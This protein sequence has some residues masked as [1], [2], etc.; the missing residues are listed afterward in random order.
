MNSKHSHFKAETHFATCHKVQLLKFGKIALSLNFDSFV[1][2]GDNYIWIGYIGCWHPS[3]SI[4][5]WI[6][7]IRCVERGENTLKNLDTFSVI[8]LMHPFSN[9][10]DCMTWPVSK[11]ASNMTCNSYNINGCMFSLKFL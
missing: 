10:L 1:D 7:Y 3:A 4:H 2:I 11:H 8:P 5:V 6:I 9:H